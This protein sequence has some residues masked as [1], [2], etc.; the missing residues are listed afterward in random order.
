MHT[1]LSLSSDRAHVLAD[2]I[3]VVRGGCRVLTDVS[4]TVS[5]ESRLAVVGENG[6]GKTTLLHVLAGLLTP[7]HGTVRR[8]GT[9][10]LARQELDARSGETVGTLT[11]EAL[12]ESLAALTE[13]DAATG[14]LADGTPGAD[15][16]YAAALD[17]ATR[18][19]AWDA[20]RRVHVALEALD[21]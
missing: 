6:R 15:D 14:D 18:L 12:R 9:V 7:D 17:A 19:D 3:T 8:A 4:V 13:L 21:A 5:H 1:T 2:G 20:E 11:G 10:G 16:R